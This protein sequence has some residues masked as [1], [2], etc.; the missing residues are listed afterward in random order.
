LSVYS[1]EH[2][3]EPTLTLQL[4]ELPGKHHR[5][6]SCATRICIVQESVVRQQLPKLLQSSP[7]LTTATTSPSL[8]FGAMS[9]I[10]TIYKRTDDFES[11]TAPS[12]DLET[13]TRCQPKLTAA[14]S[15]LGRAV[16][17]KA[18]RAE[19]QSFSFSSINTLLHHA[20]LANLDSTPANILQEAVE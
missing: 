17:Y 14:E 5:P 20:H 11:W 4:S 3:V 6:L 7:S 8:C 10:S 12:P 18:T 16:S 1:S 19:A 2:A 13:R 9:C 15:P